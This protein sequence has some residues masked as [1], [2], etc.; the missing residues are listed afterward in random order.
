[1]ILSIQRRNEMAEE[2]VEAMRKHY[3]EQGEEG[4][5]DDALRYY[6]QDADNLEIIADHHKWV[7]NGACV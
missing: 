2:I 7:K 6:K 5:F 4:D 1:V 3:E